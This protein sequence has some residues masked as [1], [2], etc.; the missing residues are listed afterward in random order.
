M[1]RPAEGLAARGARPDPLPRGILN[2]QRMKLGIDFGTTRIV[3]SAV[4]R[5][6]YPVA[7]FEGPQGERCDWYPP[8]IAVRGRSRLYGWDA[9]QAQEDPAWT[10][11]RS[12]K[13]YLEDAG[14]LT[15]VEIAGESFGMLELMTEMISSLKDAIADR[16]TLAPG[17][18][19]KFE[20][21]LGVPANA[22]GNQRFL[23]VEAF[24]RAGFEVL[25][26]LNE[27]S[28]ASVEFTHAHRGK[29]PVRSRGALLVYDLGG[30]TFDASLVRTDERT[31]SVIASEGIPTL[32]GDDFDSVLAELAM[33]LAGIEPRDRDG[34]TQ[35]E[36]FRLHEECRQKK[37]ALHPNTRRVTVDLDSVKQGWESVTVPV[38]EFYERCRPLVEETVHA[39][40]DLLEEHHATPDVVYVTGGGSELP[41]V[42]R[43]LREIYGRRVRRSSYTHS[44]TAIGLAIQADEQA[45]YVL[46]ETFTRNFGVW[47]EADAGRTIIF[48][49]LFE[50]GAPLPAPGE[51][52]LGVSRS[53]RPVHNIGHFRYLECSHRTADGRPAGDI[54]IWDE[55]L[56]PFDPFLRNE[57][58]L[59]RID[60]GHCDRAW[61]QEIRETYRCDAGGS[62]TVTVANLT[63]GYERSYRLGRWSAP[64]APLVPGKRR[65]T[66]GRKPP[67]R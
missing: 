14:P 33:D 66:K 8:L 43:A 3:A 15:R 32:G 60:I 16:S 17:P 47:R 55:I 27:P 65:R 41:L 22:N 59:D 63:S 64:A 62:V 11:L 61:E 45:G 30:G 6:N 67:R 38:G 36:W 34:L 23:T 52:P 7:G 20:V 57:K 1:L 49:L 50:K 42:P 37:E 21:M 4:D 9:W 29:L 19:E 54:T 31:H 44:A 5:G 40:K 58:H 39:V 51:S 26:L 12:L 2:E 13:R 46:K 53:Y 18:G 48:D 56:F 25:G 28:A 10:I 24:R 35:A